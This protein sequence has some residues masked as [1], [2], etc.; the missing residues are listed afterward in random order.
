MNSSFRTESKT[1]VIQLDSAGE[2]RCLIIILLGKK[3]NNRKNHLVF[4]LVGWHS[5]SDLG[6]LTR[7]RTSIELAD[8]PCRAHRNGIGIV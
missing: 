3:K 6:N 2:K 8:Q 4:R 7:M 5:R 1:R